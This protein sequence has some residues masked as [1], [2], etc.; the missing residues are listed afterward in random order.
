MTRALT[1]LL[2]LTLG[3]LPVLADEDPE[4]TSST[5]AD[6]KKMQGTWKVT[7][8]EKGGMKAPKDIV[9]VHIV[10][11]KELMIIKDPKREEKATFKLD[12]KKKPRHIDFTPQ[13]KGAPRN[14][15]AQGIYKFDGGKLIIVFNK[16]GS[17]RP[18]KFTGTSM[19]KLVLQ[20]QKEKK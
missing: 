16:P 19:V 4:P 14:E 12:G 6:L 10:I 9:G 5:K 1:L 13:I 17:P 7:D 8:A 11:D 18:T 3:A 2:L 20:K 15:T